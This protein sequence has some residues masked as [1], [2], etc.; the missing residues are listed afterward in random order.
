[1][2]KSR[3]LC[4]H[5][6]SFAGAD[7]GG[8]ISGLIGPGSFGLELL[9]GFTGA[10]CFPAPGRVPSARRPKRRTGQP[11]NSGVSYHE[12]PDIVEVQVRG[13]VIFGGSD[14]LRTAQPS[15]GVPGTL[16]VSVAHLEYLYMWSNY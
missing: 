15:V 5:Q 8:P 16:D 11:Q 9:G 13:Q 10:I 4:L 14:G 3:K 6:K 12:R 2:H 1:V 7:F